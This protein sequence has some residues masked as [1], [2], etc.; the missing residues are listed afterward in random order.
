MHGLKAGGEEGLLFGNGQSVHVNLSWNVETKKKK[1]TTPFRTAYCY[2]QYYCCCFPSLLCNQES[3][4]LKTDPLPCTLT[5]LSIVQMSKQVPHLTATE[6]S[7]PTIGQKGRHHEH[8]EATVTWKVARRGVRAMRTCVCLS[9]H[10]DAARTPDTSERDG[11]MDTSLF[12]QL[13]ESLFDP[14]QGAR[15]CIINQLH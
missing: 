1:K 3:C 15:I 14:G 10:Q 2:N 5:K 6:R 12:S 11:V 9:T 8:A 7:V 13:R 4:F